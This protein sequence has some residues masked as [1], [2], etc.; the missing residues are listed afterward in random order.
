M[1]EIEIVLHEI[2][3]QKA[4]F[5]SMKIDDIYE[6]LPIEG[7]LT[8]RKNNQTIFSEDIAVIE[9]YWYIFNWYKEEGIERKLPFIYTT[10][11]YFEPI[12]EF[13]YCHEGYW[14]VHSPWIK[15]QTPIIVEEHT[16]SSQVR[17]LICY[18]SENLES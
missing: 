11:E 17:K 6:Y 5:S 1:F 4:K 7:R 18:L 3:V 15:S 9:F 16:L 2:G 8:I 10:V 14:R 13:T 12:L